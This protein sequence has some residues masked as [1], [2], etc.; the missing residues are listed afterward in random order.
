[1]LEKARTPY[2]GLAVSPN[3]TTVARAV[4]QIRDN[5]ALLDG[6]IIAIDDHGRP[7]FQALRQQAAHRIVFY[8]VTTRREMNCIT[9]LDERT[10]W[11]VAASRIRMQPRGETS[12]DG[13]QGQQLRKEV[14]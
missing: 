4:A 3:G 14:V 12:S 1:V 7:S 9:G 6:E 2:L 10:G 11:E 8:V 13:Q 5:A